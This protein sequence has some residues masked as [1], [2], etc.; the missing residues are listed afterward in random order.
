MPNIPLLRLVFVACSQA[1]RRVFQSLLLLL[2]CT[3][4]VAHAQEVRLTQLLDLAKTRHPSIL[5]ARSQAQS[6]GFELDAAKWGKFPTVSSEVR[7]DSAYAQSIAKVEQPLWAGGRIEGRIE[8]GEANLRVAEAGIRD[9]ELNALTQVGSAFFEWLRLHSRLQT[10]LQNVQEHQ[11]LAQL[12]GRRVESEISP[13]ADAT[14][15]EAR[16]QQAITERLQFERQLAT[17]FNTL[18]QWTGPLNGLPVAPTH[19]AYTRAPIGQT[20]VDLAFQTSGQRQKLMAQIESTQAQIR[21]AQAQGMP[22]VVAGYQYIVSGPLYTAP[23]RGR[24]YVGLQFQPGAGLSALA[25]IKSAL[26][27]K[28]AAEQE[29]QMLERN[30]EFQARTLYSDI[31][32]LQAQ[33]APA[34]E[35]V[36]GT[37]ELVESYL[38][39]YQIGRK[40]WLDVLNAQREK[41]QADYNLADVRYALRQSQIKLLLLTGELHS[42]QP[43]VIHE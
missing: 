1:L 10:A 15:A 31:D 37:S 28:D 29:L 24:G 7:S 35:L 40:N 27:K 36:Q 2:T 19:I 39:Q 20:V 23:D 41:T 9:A 21:L 13:P 30:I 18:V 8:L 6:A 32:A 14:L 3:T 38:R 34:Q 25:G 11:R 5:Q 12:I 17:T 4:L 33:L 42:A 26:A 43:S 22:S 16:L